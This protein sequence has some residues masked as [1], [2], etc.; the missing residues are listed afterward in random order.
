[1]QTHRRFAFTL[2]FATL[3]LGLAAGPAQ[4]R[5]ITARAALDRIAAKLSPR[6][7]ERVVEMKGRLGQS[8]PSEWWIVVHDE[9]SP[10]RLRTLWVGDVRAT[11]E[12]ENDD[13][14]PEELPVGFAAVKRLRIDSVAAF[15]ELERLARGAKIGF[16]SVDYLLRSAEFSDEPIWSLTA[17]D[18][19]G[20]AVGRVVLSGSDGQLLRTV[21]FYPQPNG[22][23]RIVDSAL[24]GRLPDGGRSGDPRRPD[25][26][27]LTVR[28]PDGSDA[29]PPPNPGE[30]LDPDPG[31]P[32]IPP[33]PPTLDPAPD[34]GTEQAEVEE[35]VR[36][37][38]PRP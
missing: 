28:E 19:R 24:D 12:G 13:F 22:Y 30:D 36:P 18:A 8:Q 25:G 34:P 20:T 32:S 16:D 2:S 35:I 21:W 9:R 6:L 7:T 4:E 1:M 26:E 15:A 10:Y 5:G 14:Y 27:P 11:D 23:P 33:A 31:L 3:W 37:R 29:P 38:D 17:R